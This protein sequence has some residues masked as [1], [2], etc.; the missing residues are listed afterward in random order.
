MS[1]VC[2]YCKDYYHIIDSIKINDTVEVRLKDGT[3][4]FYKQYF[5]TI[6]NI[7]KYMAEI[8]RDGYWISVKTNYPHRVKAN[9]TINGKSYNNPSKVTTSLLIPPDLIGSVKLYRH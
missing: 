7:D 2:K 4:V 5:D 9:N 6:A 8:R 3:A 1:C